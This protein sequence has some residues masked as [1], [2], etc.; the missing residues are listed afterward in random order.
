MTVGNL[1][2]VNEYNTKEEGCSFGSK[3]VFLHEGSSREPNKKSER[4]WK[5]DDAPV[6]MVWNVKKVGLG[7]SGYRFFTRATSEVHTEETQKILKNQS[8]TAIFSFRRT[9]H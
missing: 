4:E 3:C 8:P 9:F 1:L 5:S 6:A 2:S 7:I